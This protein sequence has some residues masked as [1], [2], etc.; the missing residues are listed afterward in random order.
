[1][2]LDYFFNLFRYKELKK[3]IRKKSFFVLDLGCGDG[4]FI[5]I[6]N[7]KGGN[8]IG[9]DQKTQTRKAIFKFKIEN[10]R[11]KKKFDAVTLYHVIEH[12]NKPEKGLETAKKHLR[13]NGILVIETPLI[14]NLTE[15]ILGKKYFAHYDPTHKN[16]MTKRQLFELIKKAELKVLHRGITCHEFPITLI[17][18]S[19]RQNLFKGF[20]SLL[21]FIPVKIINYVKKEPNIIRLYCKSINGSTKL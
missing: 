16:L 6:V 15:K 20:I 19:F 12:L 3:F 13:S 14:G 21:I 7:K 8:A 10:F 11:T 17:T 5:K 18:S 1:M 4:T 9:V 2:N